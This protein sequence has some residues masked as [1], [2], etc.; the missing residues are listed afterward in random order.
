MKKQI[1][2][3]FYRIKCLFCGETGVGKSSIVHLTN[4]DEHNQEGEATIGMAFAMNTVELEEYPLSNK[5]LPDF[6]YQMKN[7]KTMK[8]LQIIKSHI[9]DCS[10]NIR[11]RSILPS[12]LRDVDVAFLVF[13][14]NR[15]STWE[16]LTRWKKEIE[17]NS[18]SKEFPLYVLVGSKCDLRP[19]EVS[20]EE[21]NKRCEEWNA[22]MYIVSCIQKNSSSII[23]RMMYNSYLNFHKKIIQ[24]ENENK[25]LPEHVAPLKYENEICYVNLKEKEGTSNFCCR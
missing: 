2:S 8:N 16:E 10:G 14:I 5:E 17:I 19:F 3:P 6:Y 20:M 1:I 18:K 23:K 24:M 25:E 13:D 22:D 7:E 12:Y 9:W 21:I 4:Y 15:R 11:F